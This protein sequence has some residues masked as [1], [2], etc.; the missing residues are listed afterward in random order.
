MGAGP[1]DAVIDGALV[2]IVTI[3]RVGTALP[4][5]GR[6]PLAGC[7][8]IGQRAGGAPLA[9]C[10]GIGQRA[11]GARLTGCPCIGRSVGGARLAGCT[12]L[13]RRAGVANATGST[14]AVRLPSSPCLLES[15]G[16]VGDPRCTCEPGLATGVGARSGTPSGPSGHRTGMP[17][18]PALIR[19]RARTSAGGTNAAS[20][21]RFTTAAAR[22][23]ITE[24]PAVAAVRTTT[25]QRQHA[26]RNAEPEPRH[27]CRFLSQIRSSLSP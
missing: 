22:A 18:R 12:C 7:T 23:G 1:F 21:V 20:T 19:P 2:V 8:G 16:N 5:A 26:N 27:C 24:E 17:A 6:T 9:G 15:T 10:T 4:C 3:A 25:C 13:A 11:G 14:R